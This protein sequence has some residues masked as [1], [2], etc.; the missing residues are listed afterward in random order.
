ME[1][2]MREI[3]DITKHVETHNLPIME[4]LSVGVRKFATNRKGYQR[5]LMIKENEKQ[6]ARQA[7]IESLKDVIIYYTDKYLI[8]ENNNIT[9]GK[10][11]KEITL[12]VERYYKDVL[13]EV[14]TSREL[15]GFKIVHVK[16]HPDMLR[17]FPNLEIQLKISKRQLEGGDDDGS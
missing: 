16:E 14:V 4:A 8:S 7:K 13:Y 6:L 12:T 9:K 1:V 17:A 3:V 5:K 10:A 11:V 2:K 15:L